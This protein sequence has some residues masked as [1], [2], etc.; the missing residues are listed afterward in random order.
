[1]AEKTEAKDVAAEEERKAYTREDV[2]A[3]LSE[4]AE[5]VI[6]SN[7]A[8]L[9]SVLAL[10]HLL[11]EPNAAE[12]FDGDLKEQAR[13]LW[14]KLKATGLQ[15][16]DPPVLFGIPEDF[17]NGDVAAE[18]QGE[19]E[20]EENFIKIEPRETDAEEEVPSSTPGNGG[21]DPAEGGT[22][23]S[24]SEGGSS[25]SSSHSSVSSSAS[26]EGREAFEFDAEE[27]EEIDLSDIDLER[28][29][30]LLDSEEIDSDDID[31][32]DDTSLN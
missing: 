4:I 5:R 28:L 27:Y 26:R 12:L 3:F 29:E 30:D 20:E 21:Q 6:S 17:I 13:D 8:Y 7:N 31:D 11:R 1:M 10:D 15:L 18:E 24:S 2:Q 16:N 25:E 32:D 22:E 23:M 9:H 19:E 14:V